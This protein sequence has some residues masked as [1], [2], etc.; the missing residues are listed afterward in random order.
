M[1]DPIQR[2][3]QHLSRLPGIGE[4][5][6]T[7]LAL[8]LVQ[9]PE[10]N[11]QELANA[12]LEVVHKV[13]MCKECMNISEQELCRT[14][15]DPSRDP[16]SICVVAGPADVLAIDRGNHYRGHYHVLHGL[17]S[18]LEG[19]GPQDL[20]IGE[21][22]SRLQRTPQ[23]ESSSQELLQGQEYPVPDA[24]TGYREVILATNASVEGE[25]TAMY[26]ARLIKPLGIPVS[27]IASGIPVGGELEYTDP[28][29]IAK[30]L[31]GRSTM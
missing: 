26:L 11:V 14:C 31:G 15:Q 3:V 27:R 8:H 19:I 20:C 16:Q 23:A 24:T 7:R 30:A 1:S 25:A 22:L 4:K 29:T 21:L 18:P 12:L 6:A 2:L 28:A 17:L 5:T 13:R 10:H 9:V